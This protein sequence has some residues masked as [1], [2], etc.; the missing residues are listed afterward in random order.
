MRIAFLI[1]ALSLGTFGISQAAVASSNYI[2]V[3][4]NTYEFS[5][6]ADEDLEPDGFTFNLGSHI[7]ENFIIEGRFGRSASD[8]NGNGVAL[9]IDDYIGFYTKAGMTFADMVFPYIVL[10]YSK[11]D[12]ELYNA[13][14]A[15]TESDFSYGIGAHVHY[16]DFQ[17]GIEWMK[18]QDKTEF[19]LDALSLSFG[20]RF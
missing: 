18:V 13:S 9:K 17:A 11:V 19:D 16:Q 2:A 6:D 1:S 14:I 20:W 5:Y 15:Q 12:L 4:Y 7:N 10:G 3:Q 8:D